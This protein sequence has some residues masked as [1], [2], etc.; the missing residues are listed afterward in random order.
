M[1]MAPSPIRCPLGPVLLLLIILGAGNGRTI[2]ATHVVTVNGDGSFSPPRLEI[3]SG[4]RVEWQ[5]SSRTDTIIPIQFNPDAPDQCRNYRPYDPENI[6]EFTGPMPRG[7][8]GFFALSPEESPY[9]SAESTWQNTNLAGVFIRLRWDEVHL[10]TNHYHWTE[11]DQEVQ[12]AIDHGKLYSVGFK[13]GKKGTPQWIFS[14]TSN[15]A[16]VP[17]LDFGFHEDEHPEIPVYLGSPADENYRKHYSDLIT[18]TAKHLREVN[19]AYRALACVKICGVNLHSHENR[20]PNE[21]ET[22]PVWAGLGHYTPSNL[23]RY[24]SDLTAVIAEQFPHKDMNYALIQGGFPQIDDMGVA[25]TEDLDE[26]E[27]AKSATQ[28]ETILNQGRTQHALRFVV[29]HNGLQP[30]P[31]RCPQDDGCPN[32]WVLEQ[33]DLGQLTGFQTV[34]YLTN[35]TLLE[36]TLSNAWDN[37]RAIYVELYESTTA[38]AGTNALPSGMTLGEWAER[39]HERRRT[40][41]PGLND[42]YPRVHRHHF[43]RTNLDREPQSF[44]YINGSICST[45]YGVI[46]IPPP[47]PPPPPHIDR[48]DLLK[49]GDIRLVIQIPVSGMVDIEYSND[50]LDWHFLEPRLVEAGILDMTEPAGSFL[51]G[52]NSR[53][54]RASGPP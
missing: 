39:F 53:F 20:L 12:K 22:L 24:Y 48:I 16:V 15:C 7:A 23:Y 38:L 3:A 50:L 40:E 5:F 17:A 1:K 47:P 19:A 28:T 32:P 30:K 11:L 49:T 42:P 14:G 6:N 36:S 37:T 21:P 52:P 31:E 10:G 46:V 51:P 45:N 13:A 4:D 26:G 27:A 8:S 29:A 54:F 41:W 33:G 18:A 2:G 44:Y 35:L 25:Y 34:N 43:T 9:A